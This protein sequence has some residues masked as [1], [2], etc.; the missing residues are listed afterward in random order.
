V[1]LVQLVA[2]TAAAAATAAIADPFGPIH[3]AANRAQ[4]VGRACPI[5]VVY[6]ATIN[7]TL[8]HPRGF[9]FNY[10]WERSDGAK[11]PTRVVRPAPNERRLVVRERWRLGARGRTIDASQTIHV[12]SGNTHLA[13]SSPSVHIECR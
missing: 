12:N 3:V 2:A 11:G 9:V 7:F 5:E 8:P 4:Y 10:H 13:E 1:R 6:T